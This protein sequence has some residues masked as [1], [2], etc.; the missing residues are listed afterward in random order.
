M[1]LSAGF[2]IFTYTLYLHYVHPYLVDVYLPSR[3]IVGIE[4]SSTSGTVLFVVTL[5]LST[6]YFLFLKRAL[7][8]R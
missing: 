2:T 4:A 7:K 3:G 8:E 5:L 6:T 1:L